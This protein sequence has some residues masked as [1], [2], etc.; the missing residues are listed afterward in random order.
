MPGMPSQEQMAKMIAEQSAKGISSALGATEWMN[1]ELSMEDVR[2]FAQAARNLRE[3]QERDPEFRA[4]MSARQMG[5]EPDI[6][7]AVSAEALPQTGQS[8][9]P[10]WR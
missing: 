9:S 8:E 6:Q 5:N 4:R 1:R 3:L 10:S 2:R 7:S